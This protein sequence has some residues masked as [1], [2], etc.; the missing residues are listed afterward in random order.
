MSTDPITE[1][2]VHV[3]TFAEGESDPEAHPDELHVGTF[4]EGE[5]D[6]EDHPEEDDVG[7]FGESSHR[8]RRPA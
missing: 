4:A 1:P 8:E 7:T 6:P 2:V 3:G 5:S